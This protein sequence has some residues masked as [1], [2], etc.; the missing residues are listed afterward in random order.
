MQESVSSTGARDARASVLPRCP[1][2]THGLNEVWDLPPHPFSA[3]PRGREGFS[4]VS[5]EE[6]GL[7]PL[8][9]VQ[10]RS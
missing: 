6:D 5:A 8:R 4:G 7:S 3:A 10:T 1:T 2:Q 9:V